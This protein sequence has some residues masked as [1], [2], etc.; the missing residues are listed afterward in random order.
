M[1][2]MYQ[3]AGGKSPPI[4]DD[5]PISSH[6]REFVSLC[7]AVEPN[8]RPSVEELLQHCFILQGEDDRESMCCQVLDKTLPS[9]KD[10]RMSGTS[11]LSGLLSSP[12]LDSDEITQ[13][14][15]SINSDL[16]QLPP[17]SRHIS[18]GQLLL[19]KLNR[20]VVID[21]NA[22][23]PHDEASC[24]S[25]SSISLQDQATPVVH[26][27]RKS[28]SGSNPVALQPVSRGSPLLPPTGKK[29]E[30]K[31]NHPKPTSPPPLHGQVTSPL[32][33]IRSIP[34][35]DDT[36]TR[37]RSNSSACPTPIMF[38]NN[39]DS[40]RGRGARHGVVTPSD[41][42]SSDDK[43]MIPKNNPSF[44][45]QSSVTEPNM[46]PSPVPISR[47]ASLNDALVRAIF[48]SSALSASLT[49]SLS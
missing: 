48:P 42:L 33:V 41:N 19:Q 39:S 12:P 30:K 40:N 34:S 18:E 36:V 45:S 7:C 26:Q 23:S 1:T 5:I 31:I 46:F 44:S 38:S 37:S 17:P 3:I 43:I 47:S 15:D 13:T 2:A 24:S 14:E 25:S 29:V 20:I 35:S 28:R 49:L 10:E 21:V 32:S 22:N 27:T 16:D 4:A 11:P 8:D 9:L 6:A